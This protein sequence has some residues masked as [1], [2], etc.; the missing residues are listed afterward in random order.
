MLDEFFAKVHNSDLKVKPLISIYCCIFQSKLINADIDPFPVFEKLFSSINSVLQKIISN[1]QGI[2]MDNQ[3]QLFLLYND[4][5]SSIFEGLHSACVRAKRLGVD[6]KLV[7]LHEKYFV[8]TAVLLINSTVP[9]I[10]PN[11][12]IFWTNNPEL[13]LKLNL[14]KSRCFNYL[15]DVIKIFKVKITNESIIKT[16]SSV[17]DVCIINL[18]FL[19]NEKYEYISNMSKD[20][21]NYPDYNYEM[22]IYSKLNFLSKFLTREPIISF[23][24]VYAKKYIKFICRFIFSVIFPLLAG[25]EKELVE[26]RTN[27]SEYNE[28]IADIIDDKVLE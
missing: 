7:P 14:M 21:P 15:R 2:N 22:F 9:N 6:D 16:I 8:Q 12:I 26:I 4:L 20:N 11:Y 24:S 1:F 28:F 5:C 17:V 27:G 18:D 10:W 13:N 19:L 3:F 25:T 23:F